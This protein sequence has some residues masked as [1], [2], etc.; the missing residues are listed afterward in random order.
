MKYTQAAVSHRRPVIYETI[1]LSELQRF[2]TGDGSAGPWL[3]PLTYSSLSAGNQFSHYQRIYVKSHPKDPSPARCRVF[4]VESSITRGRKEVTSH[5]LHAPSFLE[6]W[7]RFLADKSRHGTVAFSRAV[8][9]YAGQ[10]SV[11]KLKL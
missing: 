8:L 6:G 7:I 10:V 9:M 3:S 5:P 2:P 1:N 11:Q 4:G